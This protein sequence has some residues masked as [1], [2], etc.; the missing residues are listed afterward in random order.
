MASARIDTGMPEYD[1]TVYRLMGDFHPHPQDA[2]CHEVP[3]YMGWE[4]GKWVF[5]IHGPQEPRDIGREVGVRLPTRGPNPN[6][7]A[8]RLPF[9]LREDGYEYARPVP[10]VHHF[11]F[12]WLIPTETIN[13]GPMIGVLEGGMTIFQVAAKTIWYVGSWIA[14]QQQ[15]YGL[16]PLA[17]KTY[18]AKSLEVNGKIIFV[19]KVITLP[20]GEAYEVSELT[21]DVAGGP[22]AIKIVHRGHPDYPQFPQ[23]NIVIPKGRPMKFNARRFPLLNG[24]LNRQGFLCSHNRHIEIMQGITD[25][26][27]YQLSPAWDTYDNGDDLTPH[28][29]VQAP[30]QTQHTQALPPSLGEA[31]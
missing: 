13:G 6:T 11:H 1:G 5:I 16:N 9:G 29:D 18:R 26:A 28:A 8:V 30:I 23:V 27:Q 15:G 14:Q 20:S 22:S 24:C 7:G 10:F 17:R 3:L 4:P 21:S 2:Y 19:R 31:A 25:P 12:E